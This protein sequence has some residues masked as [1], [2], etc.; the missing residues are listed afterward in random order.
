MYAST[1]VFACALS[2]VSDAVLE[3]SFP[4]RLERYER[5]LQRV[6]DPRIRSANSSDGERRFRGSQ[7]WEKAQTANCFQPHARVFIA[8]A[9]GEQLESRSANSRLRPTPDASPRRG[10]LAF[11]LSALRRAEF[12]STAWWPC[13]TH[14]ASQRSRSYSGS[15]LSSAGDPLLHG[16]RDDG[17]GRSRNSRRA[18]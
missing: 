18:R 14:S 4:S 1:N 6:L 8:N 2:A 9:G 15:F 17:V 10:R 3:R 7:R 11:S 13:S 12:G 16:R 5:V